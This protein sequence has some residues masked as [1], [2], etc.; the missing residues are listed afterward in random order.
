V[1]LKNNAVH[2]IV[3]FITIQF[4]LYYGAAQFSSVQFIRKKNSLVQFSLIEKKNNLI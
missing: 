1:Q 4:S 2:K 3:H